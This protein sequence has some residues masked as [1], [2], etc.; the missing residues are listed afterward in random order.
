M[1]H[2]GYAY[3]WGNI[4]VTNGNK[5]GVKLLDIVEKKMTSSQI[6]EAQ[7]FDRECVH[8]KYKDC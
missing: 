3:M 1:E 6:V 2:L 8:K 5:D 4:A 7:K